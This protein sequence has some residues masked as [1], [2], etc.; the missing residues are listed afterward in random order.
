MRPALRLRVADT[1][2]LRLLGIHAGGPL[3]ADEGLL[4]TPCGG[5]HTLFLREPVD[6]VFLDGRARECGCIQRLRPRRAAWRGD[7]RM[8]VELPA[9]YCAAHSDYLARIRAA[10]A[11]ISRR[12]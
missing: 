5:V 2:L 11:G 7:A 10:L 4:L 1:F 8:V 9:G 3:A 6:V 12:C